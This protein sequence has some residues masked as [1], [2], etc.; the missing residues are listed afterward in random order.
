MV[1]KSDF[2]PSVPLPPGLELAAIR[3]AVEHIE[4]GLRDLVEIYHE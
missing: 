2:D 3:R 1:R 4:K